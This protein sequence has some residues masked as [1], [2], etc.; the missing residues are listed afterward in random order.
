MIGDFGGTTP[1]LLA[2]A[3]PGFVVEVVRIVLC[4]LGAVLAWFIAAPMARGLVR[5]FL[6]MP[7]GEV[8]QFF[9]RMGGAATAA[10]LIYFFLPINIG[11][12]GSGG[13]GLGEGPG[14]GS[15]GGTAKGKDDKKNTDKSGKTGKEK[16]GDSDS[17][18]R[19]A[20]LVLGGSE[21]K[22]DNK[23]YRIESKDPD[24]KLGDIEKYIET[25]KD[26]LKHVHIIKSRE[27]KD[28]FYN[29]L[30]NML[31]AKYPRIMYNSEKAGDGKE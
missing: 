22:G 18:I 4:A 27:Y 19:V 6:R 26:K 30:V 1:T 7:L 31:E 29:S 14:D 17:P 3:V 20:I 9:A 5:L 16:N 2:W 10:L 25:H 23:A 11:T 13:P 24:V 28:A 15:K 21:Y 12:G 8:G